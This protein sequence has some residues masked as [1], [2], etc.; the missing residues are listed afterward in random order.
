MAGAAS[1]LNNAPAGVWLGLNYTKAE[2]KYYWFDGNEYSLA[3]DW[4]LWAPDETG[5]P[6]KDKCVL[7]EKT[8]EED[9]KFEWILVDCESPHMMGIG[10]CFCMAGTYDAGTNVAGNFHMIW[11][12]AAL[13]VAL[14]VIR[15]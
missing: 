12:I 10:I 7:I 3:D 13:V 9:R 4:G 1:Q 6:E 15:Y 2:D 8:G 14:V 5:K 11:T